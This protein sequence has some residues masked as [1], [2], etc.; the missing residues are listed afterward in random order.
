[1]AVKFARRGANKV[2]RTTAWLF[3]QSMKDPEL[4][5]RVRRAMRQEF[6]ERYLPELCGVVENHDGQTEMAESQHH[7]SV[8]G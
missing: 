7:G 2:V 5:A 1:M 6:E 3:Y 4:D 8:N